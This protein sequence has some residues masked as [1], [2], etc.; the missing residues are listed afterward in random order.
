MFVFKIMHKV[1]FIIWAF[2]FFNTFFVS[3]VIDFQLFSPKPNY[4]FFS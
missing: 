4:L 2:S 1:N 3:K